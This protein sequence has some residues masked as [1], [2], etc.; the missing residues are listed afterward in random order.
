ML[1]FRGPL[2]RYAVR[3]LAI[4]GSAADAIQAPR[5]IIAAAVHGRRFKVF[6][7]RWPGT[8]VLCTQDAVM[9][10]GR[11]GRGDKSS[12]RARDRDWKLATVRTGPKK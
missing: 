12:R 10:R 2:G 11:G 5:P 4:R 6:P 7:G 3:R 8:G 1:I 9:F